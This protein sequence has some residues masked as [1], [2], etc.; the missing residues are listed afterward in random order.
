MPEPSIATLCPCLG[1]LLWVR[2]STFFGMKCYGLPALA[3]LLLLRDRPVLVAGKEG[4]VQFAK[5]AR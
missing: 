4:E 5:P 1:V 3:R 2:S